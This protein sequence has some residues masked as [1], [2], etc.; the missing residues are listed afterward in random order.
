[1]SIDTRRTFAMVATMVLAVAAL[2]YANA[3]GSAAGEALSPA[4]AVPQR[5]SQASEVEGEIASTNFAEKLRAALGADFGGVWFD[6]STARVHVGV[7]S[8][9]SR[10][11]AKAV[12]AQL[13]LSEVLVETPVRST[14]A[15][16]EAT[17]KRWNDRLADLFEGSLVRTGLR[18]DLNLVGVELGASVPPA[19]RAELESAAAAEEVDVSISVSPQPHFDGIQAARCGKFVPKA[20]NCNAPIVGGVTIEAKSSLC[21]A[22]PAVLLQNRPNKSAA[23]ATFILTAGHCIAN[24][25]GN[26]TSW[27]AYEK[28][29]A[30]AKEIGEA[31]KN[32]NG[33]T[34]EGLIEVDDPSVWTKIKDPTPVVPGVAM[35]DASKETDPTN[36][37]SQGGPVM[38]AKTCFSAEVSG[39]RCGKI[40]TE[41]ASGTFSGVKLEELAEVDLEKTKGAQGDSGGPFT[42]EATPSTVE[43]IFVGLTDE[44]S[45]EGRFVYYQPLKVAFEKLEKITTFPVELLKSSNEYRHPKIK[46]GSYP[47]TIHGSSTAAQKFTTEAGTIECKSSSFHAL[48]SEGEKETST[49][50]V[51]PEYKECKLAGVAMTIAMEECAYALHV[52]EKASADNYRAYTDINCPAGKSIKITGATCKAEVKTQTERET[53]DLVDDTEAS[54]KKDITLRPTLAGISY[55]VTEDGGSCPFKGTGEKTNGE[56]T[57][58]EGVTLTGQSPTEP[59]SK[60]LIEVIGP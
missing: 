19:R 47:V 30:T 27:F 56:Y 26:G 55:T 15:Q 6:P 36:V 29:S 50:T 17:L 37:V 42:A 12:A 16:L 48:L 51:T 10:V 13:G 25:G 2:A 41:K 1:M 7:T 38:N 18:P 33:P 58:A 11:N 60:I 52:A 32:I 49:V 5:S 31:I 46:A 54:P 22:G 8:E 21:S 9:S 35:W 40:I 44:G 20:A 4:Q 45:G 24:T 3:Q 39:R 28:G 14:Q 59:G 23:T 57:S 34:D 43:G 53:V